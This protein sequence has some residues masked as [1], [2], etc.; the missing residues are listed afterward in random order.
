MQAILPIVENTVQFLL[1]FYDSCMIGYTWTNYMAVIPTL[2]ICNFSMTMGGICGH[3]RHT[4]QD[5]L[6]ILITCLC[7]LP[8][9]GFF[10]IIVMIFDWDNPV[11]KELL[12]EINKDKEMD[13]SFFDNVYYITNI[14]IWIYIFIRTIFYLL[15]KK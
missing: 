3:L 15:Q 9:I 4:R 1:M 11:Q 5:R 6:W 14:L 13:W 2:S 7:L 10:I 12:R 8:Y